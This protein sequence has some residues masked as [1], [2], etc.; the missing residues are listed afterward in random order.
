M[1]HLDCLFIGSVTKDIMMHL[2]DAPL[3]DSRVV[4]DKVC[5]TG[6]GIAGTS[7]TAF[8]KLGGKAGIISAVGDDDT[9]GFIHNFLHSG[10]ISY[11][12][13]ISIPQKN[14]PFSSILVEPDGR[15]LIA[16]Y[17]GCIKDLRMNMINKT[18]L[19]NSDMIHLGGLDESFIIELARYIKHETSALVSVDG[20]N[21]SKTCID[22]L[23]PFTDVFI[24][25][26]KTVAKTISLPDREACEYFSNCGAETVCITLGDKGSIAYRNGKFYYANQINVK[27]YDTTGAGDNFHGAFLYCLHRGWDMDKTLKFCNT[28][29]GLCCEALGG[30]SSQPTLNETLTRMN[31]EFNL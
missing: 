27:A 6:G 30:P 20:G 9:S 18:A 25:D 31:S 13:L 16:F 3:R 1:D 26:N 19:Y 22:A 7:A 14:T 12:Q 5:T 4:A 2:I 24:P 28:F 8:T 17:G 11:S 21:L 23:L 29:S 15:R 10:G